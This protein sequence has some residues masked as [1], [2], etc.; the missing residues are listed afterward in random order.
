[1]DNK[2]WTLAAQES[3][4]KDDR[5]AISLNGQNI[6]LIKKDGEMFAIENRCFHMNCKFTRGELNGYNLKCPCHDWE[7]NIRTGEMTVSPEIKLALYTTKVDNGEIYI[8]I[9]G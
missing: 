7:F 4:L 6:L 3:E 1:M 5:K 2:N 9:G 8:E